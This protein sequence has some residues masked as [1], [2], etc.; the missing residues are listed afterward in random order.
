MADTTILPDPLSRNWH[1][2]SIQFLL[3]NL[4]CYAFHYRARGFDALP[5]TGGALLVINHQSFLDPL[6]VGLP[7]RRPV[8][9]LARESLFRVPVIGWI[10]R[11]TYVMPINREAASTASLREAIRRLHHGFYVGIFPEGTRT[12]TG[13]VGMF[14]PGFLLLVRKTEVPVIPV[15][16]AGAY[17]AY[18]KGRSVPR[19]GVVRVVF[20]EPLDRRELTTFARDEARLLQHVHERVVACQR[21]AQRWR[22][23]ERLSMQLIPSPSPDPVNPT[24]AGILQELPGAS[25]AQFP[26][27]VVDRHSAGNVRL[28]GD[29]GI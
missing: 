8:S 4:F 24:P 13:E 6:L 10:L 16:I 29:G 21:Q 20:G 19:P 23:G 18:P 25:P 5:S 3:Q 15:G 27:G 9:Y 28:T 7:L 2:R 1:W 17:E 14:K 22:D 11:N 12:E 26:N